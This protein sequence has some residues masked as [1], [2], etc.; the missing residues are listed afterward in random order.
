MFAALELSGHADGSAQG[1]YVAGPLTP[2]FGLKA[3]GRVDYTR[4]MLF[5]ADTPARGV[6]ENLLKGA[7]LPQAVDVASEVPVP[8]ELLALEYGGYLD[9]SAGLRWGYTLSGLSG[10]DLG[11]LDLALAY[12]A[13][14]GAHADLH[15][16]VAGDFR[17]EALAGHAPGWLRLIVRKRESS[18]FDFAADIGLNADLELRGLPAD[19]DAFLEALLGTDVESWIR[20][21]AEA[22]RCTDVKELKRRVD[23]L[24]WDFLQRRSH[25]WLGRA[26]D[27]G[28]ASEFLGVVKTVVAGYQALDERVL[29]VVK[30]FRGRLPALRAGVAALEAIKTRESL[31]KLA[32]PV[33]WEIVQT[34]VGDRLFD[35]LLEEDPFRL[36][37]QHVKGLQGVL[38][39]TGTHVLGLID[40]IQEDYDLGAVFEQLAGCRDAK[41]LRA[42]FDE[43]LKGIVERLT[44]KAFDEIA[45]SRAGGALKSLHEALAKLQAFKEAWYKRLQSSVK[46]TCTAN[47]A[48][49]FRRANRDERLLDVEVDLSSEEGTGARARGNRW[50]LR[51]SPRCPRSDA[52]TR[53]E[54]P[55]H[56]R[57][58]ED[59]PA[60][61]Q[62]RTAGS[63][64][65]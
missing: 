39:D 37:C 57:T 54:R 31:S 40:A 55:L 1:S 35:V 46:Q 61:G 36:L 50:T 5:P 9:L 19:A 42:L 58:R 56:P 23:S 49:A 52:S 44:G 11:K 27:E 34:L 65:L 26:L 18:Q 62:C 10:F 22:T 38:G 48:Y 8:G 30:S 51:A 60:E 53:E 4:L 59:R 28:T 43:K 7:R 14:I 47:L 33:A 2:T 24:S 45:A 3:G 12:E 17:I 20:L 16:R 29:R 64:R 41:A 6:I 25:Q 21:L 15:Y 13:E 63:P 32:D